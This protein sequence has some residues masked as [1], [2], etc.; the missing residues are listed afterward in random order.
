MGAKDAD[1]QQV[2]WSPAT[3]IAT[4]K[5]QLS[6]LIAKKGKRVTAGKAVHR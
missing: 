3:S 6:A 5:A 2:F 1:T 4:A